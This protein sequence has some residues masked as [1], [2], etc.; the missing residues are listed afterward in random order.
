MRH[1]AAVF[2]NWM[3]GGQCLDIILWIK[4]CFMCWI[5]YNKEGPICNHD[6]PNTVGTVGKGDLRGTHESK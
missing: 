5:A 4:Q 2:L 6:T 1:S 3:V